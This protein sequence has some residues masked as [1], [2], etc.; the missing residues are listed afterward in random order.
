VL[1]HQLLPAA[2]SAGANY[3]AACRARSAADII[4]KLKIV[5]EEADESAYW[6]ELLAESGLVEPAVTAP[7]MREVD[8]ILSMNVASIRTLR[9]RQRGSPSIRY[10]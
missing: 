8:E 5:E 1:G 7:L 3:R 10:D 4:A 2:T 6:L 9:S